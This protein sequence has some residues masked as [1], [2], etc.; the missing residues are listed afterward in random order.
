MLETKIDGY[1]ELTILPESVKKLIFAYVGFEWTTVKLPGYCNYL[2]IILLNDRTYDFNIVFKVIDCYSCIKPSPI[3]H[4][5][6]M[7][8]GAI[9]EYDMVFFKVLSPA[10]CQFSIIR[11]RCCQLNSKYFVNYICFNA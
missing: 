1:F 9:F 8:P 7:G 4:G 3:F 2:E 5:K 6:E 10:F 11:D